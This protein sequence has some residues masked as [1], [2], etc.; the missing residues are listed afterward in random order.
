MLA[1]FVNRLIAPSNITTVQW[2]TMSSIEL[3]PRP[4]V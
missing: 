4:T 2:S 1:G 3:P